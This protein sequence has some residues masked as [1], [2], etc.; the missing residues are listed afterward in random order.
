MRISNLLNEKRNEW[1]SLWE[2]AAEGSRVAEKQLKDYFL[3]L[4]TD[5]RLKDKKGVATFVNVCK[6]TYGA[7]FTTCVCTYLTNMKV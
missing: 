5:S 4:A 3:I 6:T 1:F 2:Q 7:K